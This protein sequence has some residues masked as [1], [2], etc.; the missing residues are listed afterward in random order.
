MREELVQV[1][2]RARPSVALGTTGLRLSPADGTVIIDTGSFTTASFKFA[3]VA[4]SNATQVRSQ[5]LSNAHR[6]LPCVWVGA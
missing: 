2:V 5:P 3:A 4:S 6:R 1:V